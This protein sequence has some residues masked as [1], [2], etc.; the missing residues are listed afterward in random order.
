MSDPGTLQGEASGEEREAAVR[1]VIQTIAQTTFDLEAVCQTVIDQAVRLCRAETGNLARRD[2][3]KDE[4]RVAAFT[5]MTPEYERLVRERIYTPERGSLIGRTVLEKR[6]V[7]LHDVLEDAE[8]ALPELQ[9]IAGFRTALGVPM[10]RDGEPIGAIA[11][12]RNEVHPFSDAEIRLVETFADYVVIAIE[13]VRLYQTVERQRTELARYAPQ[14]AKLLS[15][16]EGTKLLDGHRR[17][18]TTLFCDLRGF[19]TFSETA[20]PEVVFSMLREYHTTAGEVV[21]TNGGTIEHFAGDGLMA[22]FNDPV[23]IVDHELAAVRTAATLCERFG[24]LAADW[25]KRGY[26]LGLGIGVA[27]GYATLGRIGFE[28]RYEYGAIGNAV[29]LASRLSD[30]AAPG[31]ILLSQRT[32]ASLEGRIATEPVPVLRLKGFSRPV[33][34]MRFVELSD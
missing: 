5:S 23:E 2:G 25:R 3:D 24:S 10:L 17:E 1:V 12:A 31:E 16:D 22:F 20:E 30:A 13:N 9:R 32:D 18:I 29:I 19:T 14:A 6:V 11:V 15:S 28:G 33:V 8:Y 34:A 26:D 27:T 21:S 4:Y 7:H